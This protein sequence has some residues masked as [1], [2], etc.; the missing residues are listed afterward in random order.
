MKIKFNKI[1]FFISIIS[2]LFLFSFSISKNEPFV[3]VQEAYLNKPLKGSHSTAAYMNLKN[4]SDDRIVIK[5][6]SCINLLAEFHKTEISD[7]GLL[8][9]KKL[10]FII[11]EPNTE[12][13][14]EPTKEHIM[15]MG[16]G[17]ATISDGVKCNLIIQNENLDPL[18]REV[19]FI[20]ELKG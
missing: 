1:H 20:F 7:L 4:K 18:S 19:P 10:D 14:F 6:L 8:R 12:K 9:M 11:L 15:L 17:V 3:V 13:R 2:L 16:K 5:G